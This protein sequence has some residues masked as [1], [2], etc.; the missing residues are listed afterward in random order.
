MCSVVAQPAPAPTPLCFSL[1]DDERP[2]QELAVSM[3]FTVRTQPHNPKLAALARGRALRWV[4]SQ[5]EAQFTPQGTEVTAALRGAAAGRRTRH[6][7]ACAAWEGVAVPGRL[8]A[9]GGGAEVASVF[10]TQHCGGIS[11]VGLVRRAAA[12]VSSV[13]GVDV[14]DVKTWPLDP[15]DAWLASTSAWDP[16]LES[17]DGEPLEQAEFPGS[18][19]ASLAFAAR[20]AEERAGVGV[21]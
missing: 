5:G 1:R 11:R 9:A 15:A 3:E 13:L 7:D 2:Q 16:P 10:V 14:V 18:T 19:Y 20:L 4:D 21:V 12:A 8:W 17:E 6:F